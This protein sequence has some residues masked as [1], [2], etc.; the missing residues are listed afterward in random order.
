MWA[1]R[2]L[3]ENHLWHRWLVVWR[4]AIIHLTMSLVL[5]HACN[6]WL[7]AA[8]CLR[9]CEC[10]GGQHT[11]LVVRA[12]LLRWG[13]WVVI[14]CWVLSSVLALGFGVARTCSSVSGNLIVV[15]P[16]GL[17]YPLC[18]SS[19]SA[20]VAGLSGGGLCW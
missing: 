14:G 20:V 2:A 18:K 6:C 11:R 12:L 15:N 9:L 8:Y 4:E 3:K 19:S 7:V 1:L 17:A 10:T 5:S 16:P 13:W